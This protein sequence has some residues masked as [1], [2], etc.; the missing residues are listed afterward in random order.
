MIL[1][2]KLNKDTTIHDLQSLTKDFK[3]MYEIE[4]SLSQHNYD[5]MRLIVNNGVSV[6]NIQKVIGTC[7]EL[8]VD[9]DMFESAMKTVFNTNPFTT[10]FSIDMAK[11]KSIFGESLVKELN[12]K[13]I[14]I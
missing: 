1:I 8:Y 13:G 7:G 12:K 9:T 4:C 2:I 11:G 6:T 14:D 3:E 5:T 10:T